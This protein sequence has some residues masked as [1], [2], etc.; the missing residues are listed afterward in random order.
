MDPVASIILTTYNR[1]KLLKRAFLSALNQT[2]GNYEIIVVDDAGTTFPLIREAIMSYAQGRRIKYIKHDEN[3]GLSA[4]RN[5]GIK[6]AKGKY[7]VC[8]D[9]DNELMPEFLEKTIEMMEFWNGMCHAVCVGRVIKYKHFEDYAQ[10]DENSKFKAIDWG[11]LIDRKVFDNIQYDE[12]LRANEDTDFGIQFSKKYS[13]DI[14]REPLT[15]AYDTENSLSFPDERELAGM[16]LFYFKNYEEYQDHPDELRCLERLMGRKFYRGGQKAIGLNHFWR[17]FK[18]K[19]GLNSGLN[20][21][22]ILFGW[23]VYD[24]FMTVT[25]YVGSKM[26]V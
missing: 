3:K 2:Y 7:I 25:E 24:K 18:A 20:L 6:A 12:D 21:F 16:D 5:T 26:R 8:L 4:A 11:W 13:A 1:K 10:T 14:V 9:D 23:T 15:I 17:S 22:F 19:P